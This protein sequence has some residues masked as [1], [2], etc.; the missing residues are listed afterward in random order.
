[1]SKNKCNVLPTYPIFFGGGG[2]GGGGEEGL[3]GGETKHQK[4]KQMYW[5]IKVV[6]S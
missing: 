3:E 4:Q 5:P 1:M 2:G 6:L